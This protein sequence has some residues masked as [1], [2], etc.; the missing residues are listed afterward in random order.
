[1]ASYEDAKVGWE[2]FKVRDY[3]ASRDEINR[4]LRGRGYSPIS[5]RTYRHY[6]KL[7][8]YGYERYVPINQLDVKTLKDPFLDKAIRSRYTLIPDFSPVVVSFPDLQ[9][10][11][12]GLAVHLSAATITCRFTDPGEIETIKSLASRTFLR[13]QSAVAHF[14]HTGKSFHAIVE[15][16]SVQ[17]Q[18][19]VIQL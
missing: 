2:I 6:Q 15:S 4:T 18:V 16:T 19:L 13:R 5:E 10:S 3:A 7:K 8:R 1:M 11:L 12:N 17:E 14:P 9:I